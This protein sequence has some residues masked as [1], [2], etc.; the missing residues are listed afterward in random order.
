MIEFN[1]FLLFFYYSFVIASFI[2]YLIIAKKANIP[3]YSFSNAFYFGGIILSFLPGYYVAS[4]KIDSQV[5]EVSYHGFDYELYGIYLITAILI[6][7]ALIFASLV[8]G[9]KYIS[10][11]LRSNF[12]IRYKIALVFLLIYFLIYLVW[13]PSIP[14]LKL[15]TD[16]ISS[17]Y[18]SR[19]SITHG[20]ADLDPPFILRYWR[21]VIQGYTVI[22]FFIYLSRKIN[23]RKINFNLSLILLFLFICFCYIYTIE[24]ASI[25]KFIIGCMIFVRMY[26]I[27]FDKKWIDISFLF[28]AKGLMVLLISLGALVIPYYYFMGGGVS[29]VLSR[30]G[31]QDASNYLQIQYI[32]M[33]GYTGLSGLDSNWLMLLGVEKASDTSVQAIS[34]LYPR[35]ED[36]SAGA[37]GGMFATNIFFIVGWWFIPFVFI[38][39]F[40]IGILDKIFINSIRMSSGNAYSV[41]ISF[42]I[43]FMIDF[44]LLALADFKY[45]FSFNYFFS[46][47]I[48]ILFLLLIYFVKINFKRT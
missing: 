5:Y 3:L 24:K 38:F 34:D 28:R 7:I 43:L 11:S 22:L 35:D 18:I 25:F 33:S 12:N 44:S 17:A 31:G 4:G 6:P 20:F 45:I 9:K 30:I 32:R 40:L 23:P 16:G 27:D 10:F 1:T 15:I 2:F 37:A 8:N 21:S 48:I 14:I 47:Q 42:Y 36:V 29:S 13:L 39:V 41:L 46:P 26:R 19:L